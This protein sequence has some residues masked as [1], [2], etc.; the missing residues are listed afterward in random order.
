[1]EYYYNRVSEKLKNAKIAYME[2]FAA[3]WHIN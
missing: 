1:M 3:F 2:K